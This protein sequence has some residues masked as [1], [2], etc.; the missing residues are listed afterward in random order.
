MEMF[1]CVFSQ[2]SL[3][4]LA[5]ADPDLCKK[6]SCVAFCCLPITFFGFCSFFFPYK[7]KLEVYSRVR[8][9]HAF[10]KQAQEVN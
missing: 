2:G 3:Q 5:K 1:D 6:P 8:G 10:L 7:Q 4:D 9:G